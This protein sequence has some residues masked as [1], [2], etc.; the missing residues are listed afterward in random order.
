[1]KKIYT[2]IG[3]SGE[4]STL[5]GEIFRKDTIIFQAMGNIDELNALFGVIISFSKN[6]DILNKLYR[7]QNELFLLNSELAT[8][9]QKD[10]KFQLLSNKEI[11][12]LEEEI[13]LWQYSLPVINNFII[14]SG[15]K[16][17]SFIHLARAVCRRSERAIVTL[18][19]KVHLRPEVLSYINR[20]S[21]WLFVLSR[22]VN[23]KQEKI[24]RV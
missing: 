14:P 4:T 1:M 20:L 6:K 8:L 16:P 18:G 9:E 24:W 5:G 3:D 21:D 23:K 7:L 13:D 22:V 10:I 19:Q 2:H 17:C 11:A 12:M 15:V